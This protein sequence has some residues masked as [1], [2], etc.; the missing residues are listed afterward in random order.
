MKESDLCSP[1]ASHL[2]SVQVGCKLYYEV[3]TVY[4]RKAD[5]VCKREN[6]D[7]ESIELKL[8]ANLTII[9]Q[10]YNN[11]ECFNY[12]SVLIP[13]NCLRSFSIDF[14]RQLCL[15]LGIGLYLI[16]VHG[17]IKL[18]VCPQKVDHPKYS[19]YVK[20]FER[21]KEYVGGEASSKCWSEYSQTVYEIEQW[22]KQ[23]KSGNLTTILKEINHHY[24]SV[25]SGKQT[26]LRYIRRGILRQ[27]KIINDN[28]E[29]ALMEE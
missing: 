12:S 15:S 17:R 22:L 16:D 19:K 5:V 18:E 11:K 20:L 29:I 21:Q 27:F 10:A 23:H 25:S 1:L 28:N 2:S 4:D 14:L 3:K 13:K 7:L 9:Y 6:G 8:H 26:L 24:S